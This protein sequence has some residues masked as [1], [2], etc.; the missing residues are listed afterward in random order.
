MTTP[1]IRKSTTGEA[2]NRGEFG[3]HKR[4]ESGVTLANLPMPAVGETIEYQGMSGKV[5]HVDD[6]SA[7]VEVNNGDLMMLS[8]RDLGLDQQ[9][10]LVDD[11]ELQEVV[12]AIG[13]EHGEEPLRYTYAEAQEAQAEI[14]AMR[15]H[16]NAGSADDAL[17]AMI[18]SALDENAPSEDVIKKNIADT[19]AALRPGIRKAVEDAAISRD[20]AEAQAEAA[21]PA[22][23]ADVSLPETLRRRRGHVFYPKAEMRKWPAL[24]STDDV[25]VGDKKIMAHYFVG[26]SDWYVTEVDPENGIA[27]GYA[28]LGGHGPGEWGS[29][30]LPELES[31][32]VGPFNQPVE[33]DCHYSDAGKPAREVLP[34]YAWSWGHNNDD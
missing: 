33:R 2:G 25:A 26:G 11:A 18:K 34:S 9:H 24:Y 20:L 23:P 29:F 21:K 15:A 19:Q 17:V 4:D 31:I 1:K 10:V 22:K 28:Q 13:A 16:A 30:S 7:V 12:D 32:Q 5:V 8:G 14:R 6:R 3:T 27:F